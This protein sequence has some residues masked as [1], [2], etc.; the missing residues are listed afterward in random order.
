MSNVLT[1][2]NQSLAQSID[3]GQQMMTHLLILMAME[4]KKRPD[5]GPHTA[6]FCK[7][8]QGSAERGPGGV[9]GAHAQYVSPQLN[10]PV[11][12]P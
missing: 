4:S 1:T 10:P 9:Q 6:M 5:Y 3:I 11:F 7:V 12:Y 2:Q 8:L